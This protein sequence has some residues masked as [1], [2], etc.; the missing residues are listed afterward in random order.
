[1]ILARNQFFLL[2]FFI[3]V[4][5]FLAHKIIWLANSK[6]TTGSMWYTGHGNLGSALGISTY[7]VIRYK[8]GKDSLYF[9][10]NINL[11][12]KPGETVQI[13]YQKNNPSDAIA[14]DFVSMWAET[15]VYAVFPVLILVVLFFMPQR[16]DPV[17]PKKSKVVLGKKPFIQ[18]IR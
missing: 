16:F 7:S 5:P 2:L 13:R 4:T 1:V 12:L 3:V 18:I 8:A 11:D 15:L 14:D 9:N 17:I 10:S 6:Q